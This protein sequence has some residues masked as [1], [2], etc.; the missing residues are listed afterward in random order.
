MRRE[1][2]DLRDRKEAYRPVELL[3]LHVLPR[4]S[5][6]RRVNPAQPKGSS[7]HPDQ[8]PAVEVSWYSLPLVP[9]ATAAAPPAPA[10]VATGEVVRTPPRAVQADQVPEKL[11]S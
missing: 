7:F 8:A 2:R 1:Y 11:R 10:G 4:S 6:W 9:A 5:R 3:L